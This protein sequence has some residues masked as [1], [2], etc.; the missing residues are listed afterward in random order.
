LVFV[1]TGNPRGDTLFTARHHFNLRLVVIIC[2][3]QSRAATTWGM[4]MYV[5]SNYKTSIFCQ[6]VSRRSSR[7]WLVSLDVTSPMI[8]GCLHFTH[9]GTHNLC[10][11]QLLVG[12]PLSGRI[13]WNQA[14]VK[15]SLCFSK[16]AWHAIYFLS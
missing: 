9:S 2:L 3:I 12:C 4:H 11:A 14:Y 5:K 8:C 10:T 6:L 7:I 1:W 16:L 15:S 13:F